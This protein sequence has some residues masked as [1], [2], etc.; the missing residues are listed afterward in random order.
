M[1]REV[2]VLLIL[3]LS[4][5][6]V[7]FAYAGAPTIAL[8]PAVT[9]AG[10]MIGVSGSGF[11]P[12]WTAWVFSPDFGDQMCCFMTSS[13]G[14]F[15]VN[16]TLPSDLQ[17]GVYTIRAVDQKGVIAD[18]KITVVSQTGSTSTV[19]EFPWGASTV[20]LVAALIAA[21]LIATHAGRPRLPKEARL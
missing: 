20:V 3:L 21:S 1:I 13:T 17:P 6:F 9:T 5:Q 18:A 8:R 12:T 2:E 16:Y 11:T 14:S 19:P 15:E 10:K 7:Q 4:L